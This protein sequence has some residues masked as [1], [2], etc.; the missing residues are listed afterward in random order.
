MRTYLLLFIIFLAG[1]STALS[2]DRAAS[3]WRGKTAG[4]LVTGWGEPDAKIY[5]G[6]GFTQYVYRVNRTKYIPPATSHVTVIATP[7]GKAVAAYL[8]APGGRD[9][10]TS[11]CTATFKI[12]ANNIITD[13][14]VDG[15]NCGAY[16]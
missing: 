16:E 10:V 1:C 3:N 15:V 7:H 12:N 6:H 2:P 13:G 9:V 8:P 5:S 14:K 4:S 11:T